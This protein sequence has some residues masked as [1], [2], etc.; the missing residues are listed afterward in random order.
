MIRIQTETLPNTYTEKGGVNIRAF[1]TVRGVEYEAFSRSCPVQALCRALVEAGV[2]DQSAEVTSSGLPGVVAVQHA[3]IH[4][5][6]G[7]TYGE[8]SQ[9]SVRRGKFVAREERI[10]QL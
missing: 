6:A 5:E 4:A 1:C 2:R 10:G 9:M 7:F 8:S 3:S